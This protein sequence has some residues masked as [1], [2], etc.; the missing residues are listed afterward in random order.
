MVLLEEVC[1]LTALTSLIVLALGL[2]D[3]PVYL[4]FLQ[5][6]FMGTDSID[7]PFI[8]HNDLVSLS[9]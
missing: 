4:T 8:K 1:S 7:S 3:I 6:F 5:Q 2:I 9:G